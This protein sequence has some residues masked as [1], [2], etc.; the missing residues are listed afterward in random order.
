[1]SADIVSSDGFAIVYD[2]AD[3][4]AWRQA[5]AHRHLW[6]RRFCEHYVFDEEHLLIVFVPAEER[7]RRWEAHRKRLIL[8][9]DLE[10][11]AA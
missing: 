7:W 10:D 2:L 4:Y 9:R 3:P 11:E 1:M 6:G 5:H 8:G